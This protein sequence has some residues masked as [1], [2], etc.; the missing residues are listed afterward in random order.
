VGGEMLDDIIKDRID[1][2]K[3]REEGI[4]YMIDRLH[5]IDEEGFKTL[6]PIVDMVKIYGAYP[7]LIPNATLEKKIGIYHK[8]DARVSL[9]STMTE[10]AMMENV[11][12]RFINEAAV[13][14][15]DLIEISENHRD[16]SLE[17]K[18]RIVKI[19]ESKD[20]QYLWKIGR[21]DPRHQLTVDQILSRTE[22]C[23]KLGGNKVILEANEGLGVGI[24]D[25]RGAVKWH[26]MGAL[27]SRF[28][29]RV[30]IFEAP[31]ESQQ[32]AL[33]AEFGQ[34]VNLAEVR[35]DIIMAVETQRRGLLS[36]ATY[37]VSYFRREPEGGPASKFIY[38]IIKTKYP[39]E[40]SELILIS[41][42]PRRTIQNAIEDLKEQG[43]ILEKNSLDDTRRKAYY[44]VLSEWL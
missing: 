33:I 41:H 2:R 25:E 39:V 17:E 32:S 9:G 5:S 35:P 38:Y 12:E 11:F 20:L 26:L 19:I 42:L 31:F 22:E 44:P 8:Y 28:P 43:L 1:S 6:S 37:G 7:L 30:F 18:E 21:K 34:R 27:T 29:P 23:L 14:G 40:Q 24:Y 3:P 13:I 15:F 16:F 10:Y 4:T 36:K